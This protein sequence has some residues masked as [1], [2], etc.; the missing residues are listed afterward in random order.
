VKRV[1]VTYASKHGSTAEVADALAERLDAAGHLCDRLPAR[2][3]R[4]LEGYDCVVLGG[5]L[6]TGHWHRD[7]VRF[8][9]DHAEELD[10]I[11]LAVFAL[12]PRTLSEKDVAGSRAQLD[13]ALAR[14][15]VAPD[16]VRIF[17]G[18]VDPK[19]LRFPF[20]R[21]PASDA[22]DWA[23]IDA[24]AGEVEQLFAGEL[25]RSRG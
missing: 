8:L 10:C 4:S 23:A 17:G 1:L 7:A 25:S 19:K 18:A 6:Y 15:P 20:S 2:G 11:P 14:L 13:A 16:L 21:M 12:G 9:R 24:W 5:S 22:R 3:V